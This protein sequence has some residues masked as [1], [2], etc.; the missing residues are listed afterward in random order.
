MEKLKLVISQ[1][2][3]GAKVKELAQ[4]ISRDYKDKKPVFIGILKGAFIFLADLV[5]SVELQNLEI[6]FVRLASYGTS[7]KSSGQVKI[8]K[9]IELDIKNKDVLVVEDIIDTGLTLSFF[10]KYLEKFSP[11]S[12]KVCC[13]IDKPERREIEVPIH[14][15]GF[16]I[17][18]GF[19]VGYGL[20]FAEKYRHLPEVYEIIRE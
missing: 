4:T 2:K 19:L 7:D 13:L 18:Q 15:R 17:P 10:L 8:V 20:D 9:D 11:Q 14:Y 12:V 1:D 5:R 6:D 3:I 16:Y